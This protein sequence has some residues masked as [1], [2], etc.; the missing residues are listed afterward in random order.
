MSQYEG[1]CSIRDD[2]VTPG[3]G[4]AMWSLWQ[5]GELGMMAYRSAFGDWSYVNNNDLQLIINGHA[6][7]IKEFIAIG[8]D[9][10]LVSILFHEITGSRPTTLIRVSATR[11]SD[12]PSL[13][14]T[15]SHICLSPDNCV[16]KVS[17]EGGYENLVDHFGCGLRINFGGFFFNG[18]KSWSQPY[19]TSRSPKCKVGNQ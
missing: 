17:S 14:L 5:I 7:W 15:R 9:V 10:Y 12:N 19:R 2:S 1:A 3:A 13:Y 8:W 11:A 18:F 4:A 6:R 16:T